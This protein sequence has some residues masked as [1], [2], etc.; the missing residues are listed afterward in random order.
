FTLPTPVGEV[1][2]RA[3]PCPR[4]SGAL[5]DEPFKGDD[6]GK[7]HCLEFDKLDPA[8]NVD[9]V[10]GAKLTAFDAAGA[11]RPHVKLRSVDR[12]QGVDCVNHLEI[13]LP[14]PCTRVLLTL[15]HF[16]TPSRL[17]ARTAHARVVP[18]PSA[19]AP[20]GHAATIAPARPH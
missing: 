7:P 9:S 3:T 1:S 20:A 12:W 17:L 11:R 4:V 5:P 13:A 6:P 2:V 8:S 19:S 16:A 14:S 10:D 18:T 15:V